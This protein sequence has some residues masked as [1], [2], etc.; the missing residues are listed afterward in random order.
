M[1]Y[2]KTVDISSVEKILGYVFKNKQLL[3]DAFT[4]SSYVNEHR[5]DEDYERLEF[6][7]DAA[8]NYIVGMYLFEKYPTIREG[9]LTR[10]R[11]NLVNAKTL[12]EVIDKLGLINYLRIGE[13]KADSLIY[14]SHN[15]KCDVFEAIVGALI[16]DNNAD[17]TIAK[18]FI[19]NNISEYID[20]DIIDYKSKT[21]EYCAK[22]KLKCD[23]QTEKIS[24]NGTAP[25]FLSKLFIEKKQVAL[26]EGATKKEA[27]TKA[28]KEF[29]YKINK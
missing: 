9:E 12:S 10:K 19:F 8:L 2:C 7:G 16:L 15:V 18:K 5:S 28:C 1:S 24:E 23:I 11:A 6:L 13:G 29:Y 17:L 25:K 3:T 14:D 22:N 27:E 20:I 26:S 4:H 21:L